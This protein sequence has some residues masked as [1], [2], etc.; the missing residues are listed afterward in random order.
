MKDQLYV[1]SLC[2]LRSPTRYSHEFHILTSHI[3]SRVSE[4]Y[5]G[6][7]ASVVPA[8]Y[9]KPIIQKAMTNL[10]KYFQGK[11]NSMVSHSHQIHSSDHTWLYE[12]REKLCLQPILEMFSR[13]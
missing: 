10:K 3:D 1:C 7:F 11:S 13:D 2:E 5:N 4:V 12:N 8:S 6:D 9:K